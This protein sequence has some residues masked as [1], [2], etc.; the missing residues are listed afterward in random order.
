M[1]GLFVN[2]R[3]ANCSIHESGIMI[4]NI[5]WGSGKF[6]LDYVETDKYGTLFSSLNPYDFYIIN[7]HHHTLAMPRHIINALPGKKFSIV[8][9]TY[10]DLCFEFTPKDWFD[11]HLV[12]D[13]TKKRDR[14]D[15]VYPFPRPLEVMKA[16][17]P[18][19]S[20]SVPVIGSFGLLTPG[21]NYDEVIE[22]AN[23]IGECIVRFNFPPVTY[24]GDI[25]IQ[26]RLID[27]ANH[28]RSLA[29]PGVDLRIT[30]EYMGKQEL[31]QWCS[32]NT[33]NVFPYYRQQTGLAATTDQA[34]SAG[35][36]IAVTNC[37]TFRHMHPYI[38]CY[39]YESYKQLMTS[40][41]NGVKQMQH[42]WR[43]AVFLERFENML[44]EEGLS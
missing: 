17:L 44:I 18:L 21:K 13:P 40:T 28:L 8:M 20:D 1:R 38:S 23:Q 3:K 34:I 11:A 2:S 25:G 26:Q 41:L 5:L 39:P 37:H 24:M 22:N 9:E 7:W 35:R 36:A 30:H 42:D 10:P 33:I 14:K 29:S 43:P 15:R 4:R 19:L 16:G 12:I 27:Y 6:S 32:E 31:I